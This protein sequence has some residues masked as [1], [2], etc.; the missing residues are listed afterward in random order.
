M[1]LYFDIMDKMKDTSG[2]HGHP[3][4]YLWKKQGDTHYPFKSLTIDELDQHIR[5]WMDIVLHAPYNELSLDD[6]PPQQW[7]MQD[8]PKK[9]WLLELHNT[10]SSGGDEERIEGFFEASVIHV[11]PETD[12]A[13]GVLVAFEEHMNKRYPDH[14]P[15]H[16]AVPVQWEDYR[17]DM[18]L[19]SVRY[20]GHILRVDVTS[21]DTPAGIATFQAL[22]G[23]F[24]WLD[25]ER[26]PSRFTPRIPEVYIK[27]P[28]ELVRIAI[29]T[30]A[31]AK[32]GIVYLT[33]CK[34]NLNEGIA[35]V[36]QFVEGLPLSNIITGNATSITV[37]EALGGENGKS[38]SLKI[39]VNGEY[40][41]QKLADMLID[42]VNNLHK[43]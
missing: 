28:E 2:T 9:D 14:N 20:P 16:S 7:H 19:F 27:K 24:E 32:D 17:V 33:L 4:L 23:E 34:C 41:S 29:K 40:S 8:L 3:E 5:D 38:K 18:I 43:K 36:S 25:W 10:L 31:N 26:E 35:T 42:F 21:T 1:K 39:Y 37:R 6:V 11:G 22:N 12:I 13:P 30:P 15:F